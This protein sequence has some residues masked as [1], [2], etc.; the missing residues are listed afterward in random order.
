MK[1]LLLAACLVATVVPAVADSLNLSTGVPGGATYTVVEQNSYNFGATATA[2][3]VHPGDPDWSTVWIPNSASSAWIAFDPLH[4][5]D[6]GSG[7]YSTT[8]V[9]TPSDVSTVALAGAWTEDDFGSLLLNGH[10]LGSLSSGS[11]TSLTPFSVAAGSP[12]F[13]VGVN[14]LSVRITA[15][16]SFLEGINLQGE[17]TGI[18]PTPEPSSLPWLVILGVL[19][20]VMAHFRTRRSTG[21]I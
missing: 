20:P 4:C 10:L 7:L 6:N 17:L 18:D 5:C 16:D 3:V 21:R 15:T 9:L 19:L 2:S 1:Q 12:D 13:V 11:W 14:T 8:F